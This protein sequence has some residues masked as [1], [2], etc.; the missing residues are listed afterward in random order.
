[1]TKLAPSGLFDLA[2]LSHFLSHIQYKQYFC[3]LFTSY[4]V[5]ALSNL[6]KVLNFRSPFVVVMSKSACFS[7][8]PYSEHVTSDQ[9]W[10][11]DAITN[12]IFWQNANIHEKT[13]KTINAKKNGT[14]STLIEPY[15]ARRSIRISLFGPK[16]GTRIANNNLLNMLKRYRRSL[17]QMVHGCRIKIKILQFIRKPNKFIMSAQSIGFNDFVERSITIQSK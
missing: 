16:N 13:K 1:M 8:W 11:S 3:F 14:P 17:N 15:A 10:T 5:M 12:P 4:A 6:D 9:A 2:Y 7:L